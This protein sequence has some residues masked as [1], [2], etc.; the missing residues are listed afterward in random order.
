M[1]AY[2][3]MEL[4]KVTSKVLTVKTVKHFGNSVHLLESSVTL[5]VGHMVVNNTSVCFQVLAVGPELV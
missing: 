4:L 5:T 1:V 3:S 2:G